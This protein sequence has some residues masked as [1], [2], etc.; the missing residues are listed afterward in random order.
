MRQ[1]QAS[2]NLI[3]DVFTRYDPD[4]LLLTQATAEVLEQHFESG[5]FA[6]TLDRLARGTLLFQEVKKPTPLALPLM[7]DRF[8]S[9]LSTE[10]L[11]DRVE[12]L[13][14]E[15]QLELVEER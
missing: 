1:L 11:L 6:E 3:Y 9:R 10:D 2:S 7:L 13:T 4:N 14:R 15:W 12:R 8:G 5:R